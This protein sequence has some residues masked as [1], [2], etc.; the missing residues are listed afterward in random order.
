M[1]GLLPARP[2]RPHSSAG[3]PS[4]STV[5]QGLH[6]MGKHRPGIWQLYLRM[7]CEPVWMGERLVRRRGQQR[8]VGGSVSINRPM[9][10]ELLQRYLKQ[11][12]QVGAGGLG[13]LVQGP[14]SAAQG[15]T[16]GCWLCACADWQWVGR[17]GLCATLRRARAGRG[18]A[19]RASRGVAAPVLRLWLLQGVLAEDD[20]GSSSSD[21]EEELV[22]SEEEGEAAAAPQ[23]ATPHPRRIAGARHAIAS[24]GPELLRPP[25]LR[26]QPEEISAVVERLEAENRAAAAA[27]AAAA[28]GAAGPEA[29]AAC[30]TAGASGGPCKDPSCPACADEARRRQLLL[31]AAARPEGDP[32][33]Y[34]KVRQLA[35]CLPGWLASRL[36][37][38]ESLLFAVLGRGVGATEHTST[39]D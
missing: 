21:E 29:A 3:W 25:R 10:A 20:E 23:Q 38:P 16:V 5:P 14:R 7:Q 12:S 39:Q 15:S 26:L 6:L 24:L 8:G 13:R 2:A 19:Q 9:L 30:E 11:R 31:E 1:H 27:V 37:G 36:A 33:E 17:A 35:G 4:S 34:I 22:L 28:G 18:A 32:V